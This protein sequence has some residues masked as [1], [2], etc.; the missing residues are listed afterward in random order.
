MKKKDVGNASDV[1][2]TVILL[3]YIL[4]D[5]SKRH[6]DHIIDAGKQ[7]EKALCGFWHSAYSGIFVQIDKAWIEQPDPDHHVCLNC[8]RIAAQ[9]LS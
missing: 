2:A 6:K 8:K 3:P 4:H 5:S 7:K 1:G 9:I